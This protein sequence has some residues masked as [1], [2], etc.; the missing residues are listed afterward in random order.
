M[1]KINSGISRTFET[2]FPGYRVGKLLACE[3]S[4][5]LRNTRSHSGNTVIAHEVK[6]N[7]AYLKGFSK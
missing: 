2:H 6:N 4:S 1:A 3:I 7:A 5:N